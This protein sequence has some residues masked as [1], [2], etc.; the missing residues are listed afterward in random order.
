VGDGFFE[1]LRIPLLAGRVIEPRD[2]HPNADAV[3][4]DEL[5]ARRFFPNQNPLGR[6]F[7]FNPK[8]NNRFEIVGVVR[9]TR[10]NS[11][12]GDPVPTVY[13]PYLPD[14]RDPIHFAIR[15]TTDSGRLAQAVRT[16]VASVD[17]AVPLTDFLVRGF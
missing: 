6:R 14:P 3:V 5:F 7:G 16:A 9:D 15:T 11:L 17:P 13:E 12:R 4:V 10:Y 8:E 2:M 1:T